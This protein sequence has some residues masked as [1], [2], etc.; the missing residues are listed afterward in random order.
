MNTT[1]GKAISAFVAIQKLS[2][3]TL[4]TLTAYKLFRMKKALH[5][6]VDFQGEQERKMV[7]KY[8]GTVTP[9]GSIVILDAEKRAAFQTEHNELQKLPCEVDVEPIVLPMGDIPE[10]SI[11]DMEALEGFV[12]LE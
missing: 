11:A 10:I 5:D 9:E 2:Q 8:N 6:I 1:Q 7:D 3:K 12:N 4:P